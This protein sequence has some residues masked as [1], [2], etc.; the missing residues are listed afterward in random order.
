MKTFD[1]S[2]FVVLNCA[3]AEICYGETLL[4]KALKFNKTSDFAEQFMNSY[5]ELLQKDRGDKGSVGFEGQTPLHVAIVRGSLKSVQN[6]LTTA[7]NSKIVSELLQKSATGY[8][9]RNTVLMGQL[10]L[11]VAALACKDKNFQI[12]ETLIEKGAVIWKV[13]DDGDT[14]FHSLIK[15]ADIYPDKMADIQASFEFLW[16]KVS[17]SGTIDIRYLEN[18][19]KLT[20]LHLSAKLGVSQLFYFIVNI[21]DV[22]CFTNI[23]D[24]LFDIREYDVTEFDRLIDYKENSENSKK[25]T[26]L[27]SLFDSKCTH[28]EAFEIL[29]QE[30]IEFILHKKWM[31][32]RIPLFIWMIL[33]FIFMTLLTT[34]SINKAE[35]L[36][37]FQNNP[38]MCDIG[39]DF[40]ALSVMNVLFGLIY[41]TFAVVCII[42][43]IDRCTKG[44]KIN[45]SLMYHNLDYVVCL[46]VLSLA[47]LAEAVLIFLKIHWDYHLAFALICGWYF[48]LYFSPFSKNLVSFTHMI[49]KGFLEDFVPFGL[50]F[51]YLL[52]SFT[53]VMHVLFLGIDEEVQEFST[54][55]NSI[56]TMFNLGV[57]LN[58]IEVLNKARI[59]WL[60][61]TLFVVFTIFSFIHLFNALVAVMS[62]TFSDVH[63]DKHSYLSYNKLRMIELFEDIVLVKVVINCLPFLERAK[64]WKMSENDEERTNNVNKTDGNSTENE[65]L[66]FD[67][68]NGRQ[69][70]KTDKKRFYSVLHLLDDPDDGISE[71]EEKKK[72][73]ES[74][75]RNIID[76]LIQGHQKKVATS[77]RFRKSKPVNEI[78]YVQVETRNQSSQCS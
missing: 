54:F 69:E 65:M 25:L 20:P 13:N 57:G 5:P 67:K 51:L 6:I 18:K 50:V 52:V 27:E 59:P 15:Y 9:F 36:F 16:E 48:M 19:S 33:H 77:T 71:K 35:L 44:P 76:K 38:T 4:H 26:I 39:V 3:V 63:T 73:P 60:A 21:Q 75:F 22:Y 47:I 30:L 24:G 70:N 55:L 53:G 78:T 61:Y 34:F 32:Y 68:E 2:H 14:V 8:K 64:H 74:K 62:Q 7:E 12:M 42:K 58:N 37:C 56:L 1:A 66:D 46:F 11:H 41:F 40:I 49:K 17:N 28:Q 72:E 31:A 23:Q 29:N 43:L 45:L 10:P